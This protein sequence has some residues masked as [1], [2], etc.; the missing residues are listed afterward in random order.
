MNLGES[1]TEAVVKAG[2]NTIQTALTTAT[3]AVWFRRIREAGRKSLDHS[4]LHKLVNWIERIARASWVYRWFTRE[5]DPEVVVIDL[6]D[7]VTIGPILTLLEHFVTRMRRYAQ[8]ATF[9]TVAERITESLVNHPIQ[10]V[11]I[12]VLATVITNLGLLIVF[13][14]PSL[15]AIGIRLLVVSLA[16]AGTRMTH[17]ASELADSQ[18]GKLLKAALEPPEQPQSEQQNSKR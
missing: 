3:V 4:T 17:S 7:T 13:E 15:D 12:V 6:R 11:S 2:R 9:R 18:T 10:T 14:I 5:P 1:R 8:G 16:L